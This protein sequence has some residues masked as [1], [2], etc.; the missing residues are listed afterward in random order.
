MT[1]ITGTLIAVS[2]TS[3]YIRWIGLEINTL[4]FIP[5]I[6]SKKNSFSTQAA[7]KYFL[8]QAFRSALLILRIVITP[9]FSTL[10]FNMIVTALILKIG[11]AP[12]HFWLPTVIQ[13]LSWYQCITLITVQKIAPMA[14]AYYSTT[15]RNRWM[16]ILTS[17][18]SAVLGRIGGLNQTILRKVIAYSSIRHMAWLLAAIFISISNW[19]SYFIIYRIVSTTFALILNDTQTYHINQ[20]PLISSAPINMIAIFVGLFSLGGLPPFLGFLPKMSVTFKMAFLNLI[21]WLSIL[22]VSRLITLFFYTRLTLISLTMYTPKM[23]TRS[24]STLKTAQ[25]LLVNI[26]P[27]FAPIILI[28]CF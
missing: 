2:S 7:L 9:L 16:I 10:S 11:A 3:W 12:L 19:I 21:P 20:L 27:T 14:L 18:L 26:L 8:I 4:S 5:L 23:K 13:N 17:I 28:L 25:S 1:L 22:I 24:A 6:W 15:P